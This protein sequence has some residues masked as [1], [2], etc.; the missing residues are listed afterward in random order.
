MGFLFGG[1]NPRTGMYHNGF[2][3]HGSVPVVPP[4][5]TQYPFGPAYLH[6]NV[7]SHYYP[8][9][10]RLNAP[11][12]YPYQY[13]QAN[14]GYRNLYGSYQQYNPYQQYPIPTRSY[15]YKNEPIYG[16]HTQSSGST[17]P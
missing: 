11:V 6:A 8:Y 16:Y 3:Q 15:G 7:N 2:S 4:Y 13:G 17:T 14:D 1:Q 5:S 12:L 9:T 10:H